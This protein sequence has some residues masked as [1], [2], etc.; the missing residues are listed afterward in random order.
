MKWCDLSCEFAEFPDKL[1]DGSHSCRT[2]VGIYCRKLQRI[3]PKNGKCLVE[4]QA[5]DS[6]DDS[7]E[8]QKT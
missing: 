4:I 8:N 2:F 6:Q 3:V 7:E 1:S 5:R